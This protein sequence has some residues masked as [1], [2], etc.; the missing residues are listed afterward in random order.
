MKCC[1]PNIDSFQ[2]QIGIH[3]SNPVLLE[4]AL[5][6]SSYVNEH[7][8]A[9]S[10]ERMEFLGDALLG[11]VLGKQLY[12]DYPDMDE[13][14]LTHRRSLLICGNTLANTARS[15]GLGNMLYLGKGEEKNGGRSKNS[16]LAGALEALI[17]SIMLDQGLESVQSFIL[18]IL[19]PEIE[20]LQH[21]IGTDYKSQFQQVA[22]AHYKSTP[23]YRITN[24][25]GVDHDKHFMAEV[26]VNETIVAQ[27]YGHSKK[28][29]EADAARLALEK[30]TH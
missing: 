17:A 16:N 27:G 30:N 14:E 23:I 9:T 20:K 2:S 15:I 10:N 5:T 25:T 13:G 6:H 26:V 29:A 4:E 3:W 8:L 21:E 19:Q 18:R 7:P 12:H 28:L 11:L 24:M 1:V 22:Q